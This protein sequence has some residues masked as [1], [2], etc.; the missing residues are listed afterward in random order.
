EAGPLTYEYNALNQITEASDGT[1][2]DY[3]EDGRLSEVE[4][5]EEATSYEW[6]PF[7][8]PAKVEGPGGSAEYSYDALGRLTERADGSGINETHYG[9]LTDLPSYDADSEGEL[10]TG[11]VRGPGGLL[12]EAGEAIAYPIADV[13]GDVIAL[14]EEGGGVASRQSYDPWG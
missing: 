14:T 3:D 1:T 5:G 12:E 13:H 4:K 8:N 10:T 6:D 11:Y 9:D 2:Y 7:D